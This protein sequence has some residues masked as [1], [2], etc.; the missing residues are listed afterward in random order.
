MSGTKIAIKVLTWSDLSFFKVHS[1]RSNQRAL[2]LNHEIFIERFYP[3]LQLSHDQVLFALL[4]IDP[5]AR[6]AHRL[7]RMAMRSL[8]SKNWHIKGELIHEPAEEPGRYDKLAENDF[9]IMA[10]EGNERPRAVRLT[11]VSAVEAAELHAAIADRFELPAQ[12]AM[13]EVSETA[14]AHLRASTMGAYPD[15]EHPLDSFISG[16]TIEDVLFGTGALA[17]SG[18]HAPSRT[19]IAS[20]EDWHRRLLTA[21]ETRQRGEEL[22]GA[23]LTTTGHDD[24]FKW[25]SQA[26]PRSA[27]DYEV[28]A[29]RWLEGAPPVFVNV[30]ATRAAFARPIHMT[31]SELRFAAQ[32]ENCRIARLYDIESATPKLRILTGIRAI[33]ERLIETLNALPDRVTADSLQ[34]DPGLF[35]VELQ[36][37]L[38]K[39]P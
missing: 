31:L 35:A 6:T 36:A 26:L 1:M 3:G 27:Y 17:S 33:A 13:I 4:I 2:S 28:H 14:L 38:Q 7:T 39:H 32:R 24:D 11:L 29:A 16:E 19:E 22:F 25:V 15:G 8:G 34:L 23:W 5:G 10:F 21:E 30:R 18:V 12:H 37:N 20:P 9:A